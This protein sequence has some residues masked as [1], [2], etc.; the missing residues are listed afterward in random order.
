V[1]WGAS[2]VAWLLGMINAFM[3]KYFK[4]PVIGDYA[5]RWSGR[6]PLGVVG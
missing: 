3:G 1:V 4:L 5:E 6:G 2:F